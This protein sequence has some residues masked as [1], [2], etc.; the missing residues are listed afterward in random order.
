MAKSA[1]QWLLDLRIRARRARTETRKRHRAVSPAMKGQIMTNE[2]PPPAAVSSVPIRRALADRLQRVTATID[3][4]A[5]LPNACYRDAALFEV[6]RQAIFAE[7]WFCIGFGKDVAGIGDVAPVIAFDTPL[8][9]VRD[10]SNEIRVFHN[11]C[12]HR[13][14]RLVTGAGHA[15]RVIRCPY[16][17]WCYRLDG[18]LR[19]NTSC[20]R[21]RHPHA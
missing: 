14:M 1:K 16:H 7:N 20:G 5:G 2:P 4:S 12:R 10:A 21:F 15:G 17:S 13:G 8:V 11:V 9:M 19:S 6:E 18:R 3:G